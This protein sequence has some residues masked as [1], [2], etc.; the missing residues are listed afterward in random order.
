[1]TTFTLTGLTPAHKQI[2]VALLTTDKEF[3]VLGSVVVLDG[4]A[5][6]DPNGLELAYRFSFVSVPI[7]SNVAVEGFR[8]LDPVSGGQVSFS[9]DVVGQYIIGLVVSNGNFD[10]EMMTLAVDVRAI[11]IPHARGMV[12]DGKF[13][14]S[15]LRDVWT[16]VEGRDFF[17]TLWSALIQIS[18]SEMLKLYQN[19]FNKSIADIQEQYQRRW[20][21]YEPKLNIVADDI[22]FYLSGSAVG[23]AAATGAIA[24]TGLALISG[25][26][27]LVIIQGNVRADATGRTFHILYSEDEL[28]VGQYTVGGYTPT[29]NGIR[30]TSTSNLHSDPTTVHP[31]AI[32]DFI[33]EGLVFSFATGSKSWD[34][35]GLEAE[36]ALVRIGDVI[37]IQTGP[38]VGLYRILDVQ[39]AEPP[40]P[41]GSGLGLIAPLPFSM[42]GDTAPTT[43]IIVD[44]APVTASDGALSNVYRPIGFSIDPLPVDKSD[45]FNIPLSEIDGLF[46]LTQGQL[47]VINGEARSIS[48]LAADQNQR[49]PSLIGTT[50]ERNIVPGLLSLPWRSVHTLVSRSQD[51]EALGVSNGD[52][53]I[54]SLQDSSGMAVDLPFQIYGVTGKKLGVVLSVEDLDDYSIPE[55]PSSI[56]T[57]IADR[58][59]IKNVSVL[60]DGSVALQ[61][62]ALDLYT[63]IQSIFFQNSYLNTELTPESAIQVGSRTFYIS[64]R[65]IIRNRKIPIDSTVKSVP[66]LQEYIKQPEVEVDNG[67]SYMVKG[68][69]KFQL[70][71]YPV[72]LN[73][74]TGYVVDGVTALDQELTFRSGTDIIEADG[75]DFVDRGIG[76]GDI[77]HISSPLLLQGDYYIVS[78]L[79]RN[80]LR[81]ARP[82]AAYPLSEFVTA[83]ITITR[84]TNGTFLRF[85]PGLFSAK[86]PAPDRM[87]AEVTFFDNGENIERN[88]GVLVGLKQKDIDDIAANATYRQAVAGLMYAYVSGPAVGKIRLGVSLLLG[89][90]F[91]EK[92]GIIRSIDNDYRLDS[93]GNPITGR[94]LI[95]DLDDEDQPS[96]LMRIYTFPIDLVSSTLS[97]VDTNPK[98]GVQY[99]VGDVVEAFA[100][101]ARGVE[102]DDFTTSISGLSGEELLKHYHS[103]R[104]RI[105]DNIFKMEEILLVSNFLR[106]ITPSYIAL[107][108][109]SSSEFADTVSIVD[110]LRLRLGTAN[111]SAWSPFTDFVGLTSAA[112]PAIDAKS[113]SGIPM[114][115]WDTA[116]YSI[117]RAG[118]TLVVASYGGDYITTLSFP[119]GGLINPRNL[120][121]EFAAP[122]CHTADDLLI[123][124]GASDGFYPNIAIINDTTIGVDAWISDAAPMHFAVVRR[125]WSTEMPVGVPGVLYSTGL[126][127]ADHTFNDPDTGNSYDYSIAVLDEGGLGL[128]NTGQLRSYSVAAGDWMIVNNGSVSSR[129]TVMAVLPDSGTLPPAL[130]SSPPYKTI[131]VTPPL[132]TG[133]TTWRIFH[134]K[135]FVNPAWQTVWD[136]GGGILTIPTDNDGLLIRALAD[137]GDELEYRDDDGIL[138]RSIIIDPRNGRLGSSV[139][140]GTKEIRLVKKAFPLSLP[141]ISGQFHITDS[142]LLTVRQAPSAPAPDAS[143]SGGSATVTWGSYGAY[144][145]ATAGFRLGDFF[146]PKT[147]LGSNMTDDIGYGPGIYPIVAVSATT[148]TLSTTLN[149]GG[150]TTW[151]ILRRI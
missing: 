126:T 14:W 25:P 66:A 24:E 135:M 138:R 10:S 140:T 88:F 51:F 103:I 117:R 128:Y 30:L 94:I 141:D 63:K 114:M 127:S 37:I 107:F 8:Q 150:R 84:R 101:L 80:R 109:S 96:G 33:A 27:E 124:G 81:L 4:R 59:G 48:R 43:T 89:L 86:N 47:I 65:L 53:L 149:A 76:A 77:F 70:P 82:V 111:A 19:D 40:P 137:P 64:P 28:N 54:V 57:A 116:P 35:T 75:G 105:N 36:L 125:L 130:G 15:Y 18:G 16:Q 45:S 115:K 142:M 49:I 58:F 93:A 56:F 41:V 62:E 148:V 52:R 74:N 26:N 12:P 151:N 144:D 132:L 31:P 91:T 129:H 123:V 7:G 32:S 78:V 20:L 131:A 2:P 61:E 95:E 92:R 99:V 100:P 1:M 72:A 79:S 85:I 46:D 5:S 139:G 23:R 122:L 90:P 71:R 133:F 21:K 39:V 73:E 146:V 17:E 98:T 118:K 106:R 112:S 120:S 42:V 145:P 108:I 121:E 6:I 34:A 147:A 29:A 3:T 38:N 134:S 119:E 13:I 68:D 11:M 143:V 87:W 44:R 50:E 60:P 55:I 136:T 67:I 113:F 83:K 22:A 102:I 69:K 97:G 104:V 9:P 110:V